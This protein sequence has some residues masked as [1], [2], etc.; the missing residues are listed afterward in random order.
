MKKT[1]KGILLLLI[2]VFIAVML[3]YNTPYHITKYHWKCMGEGR[4]NDFMIFKCSDFPDGLTLKW[5]AIY[6]KAE[7][8]VGY[9]VFCFYD[10]LWIYSLKEGR[11]KGIGEYVKK[12]RR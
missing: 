11:D 9:V 6:D 5:P 12:E 2:T 4:I 7:Q 10:R 1:F 3:Y 8:N